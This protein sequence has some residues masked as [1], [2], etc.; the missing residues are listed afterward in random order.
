MKIAVCG[1]APSSAHLA[2]YQD[3][4]SEVFSQGRVPTNPPPYIGEEWEIWGCS[5]G[6]YGLA[7]R[8]TRWFEVHRWEPG[9]NWFSPE[10]VQFLKNF[11]GP[12][13]T[14]GPIP[15]IPNH[16]VYPL[17]AVEDQFSA[18]FL[19]SSLSLMAAIAIRDIEQVRAARRTANPEDLPKGVSEDELI[20]D[21]SD[22][23]IGFWGVDMSANEEYCVSPETRIL[24]ADLR[25]VRADEVEPGDEVI[26]FDE[27]KG[28]GKDSPT[29]FRQWRKA[30]VDKAVRLTRPCYR[31]HMADGTSMVS[32][33]EHRWLT[34]AEHENRWQRTD[35]LAGTKGHRDGKPT[36]IVKLLNT[37]EED[38]S[39]DAG[40]LAAAFDG[41]GYIGQRDRSNCNG[42]TMA[43][44]FAQKDNAMRSM[45]VAICEKFGLNLSVSAV[46]R[47]NGD[48]RKVYN[49]RI[50]GGK[51]ALLEFL[52]KI[53][54]RRL[55]DN[56]DAE[57]MGV[58]HRMDAV[59]VDRIEY[60]GEQEVIGLA[61]S[62]GTFVAEGFASHNSRQKPG[63]WYFGI[64]ILERNIGLYYPPESDLF[65]PEPIYGLCE[66]DHEYIKATA[67]MREL[68]QRQ[69]M[70]QQNAQMASAEMSMIG[71][72][73]DDLTYMIKNWMGH[74]YR[75][76][77]GVVLHKIK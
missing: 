16:V 8:A 11:K 30:V 43:I 50:N 75:L 62:T 69:N 41:D 53:R 74:K 38:R 14:G 32:S 52:G 60:I 35:K 27:E 54:P 59:A 24:T 65:C 45:V 34:Y 29:K 37:W 47:S 31:I 1:S 66:W 42:R 23:V 55:L 19:T 3:K 21:D 33:A 49:Y 61:T 57:N 64:Q 46:N 73:R 71:G 39:W 17:E 44:G 15:E 22:D 5:P 67:R 36:R 4:S 26:A 13:Y 48:D 6:L 9:Q 20:K 70:A 68:S 72:A 63:C 77:A 10:Y 18:F 56:F 2:P 40:Y 28:G 76:Q 58:M 25:W 12:V 51:P 7:P